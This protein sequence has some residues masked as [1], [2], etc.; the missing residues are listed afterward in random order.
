MTVKDGA[1]PFAGFYCKAVDEQNKEN[2][3]MG[4]QSQ[5]RGTNTR[6]I[7]NKPKHQEV[8]G[9]Q[10]RDKTQ[11]DLKG[12]PAFVPE[13]HCVRCKAH[14]QGIRGSDVPHKAHHKQ[15]NLAKSENT[16]RIEKFYRENAKKN[17][18]PVVFNVKPTREMLETFFTAKVVTG[19]PSADGLLP[20]SDPASITGQPSIGLLLAS[21]QPRPSDTEE[22]IVS[23]RDVVIEAMES[24]DF[25]K[26][27]KDIKRNAPLPLVAVA[28]F[29]ATLPK[30]N[31][32]N[33]I[34]LHTMELTVPVHREP[35]QKLDPHYHSIE[36]QKILLVDWKVAFPGI[37]LRCPCSDCDGML[38]HD[39]SNFS[40]NKKLFPLF[41]I[42][43]APS[44]CIVM[45]Y[46]CLACN[47]KVNAN[48]GRLLI[49]LPE[50]VR[51]A[52]PVD[53]KYADSPTATFHIDRDCSALV[54]ELMPT[55]GNG[56]MIS[57]M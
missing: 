5:A 53:P 7:K 12:Q 14:A 47:K 8:H 45:Q 11:V 38:K 15:C 19:G 33:Y 51:N 1:D 50:Y 28:K 24:P 23:L 32:T 4:I 40:K 35:G 22:T 16:K 48:D 13:L 25:M 52:Y 37:E 6:N 49:S 10:K 3:D 26:A 31:A 17:A 21:S 46:T 34:S 36:G 20:G 27:Y 56:D 2:G 43:G 44:W 18:V 55:Y 39:R 54:D 30:K 57:R 41:R 29:I 9:Q 42:T